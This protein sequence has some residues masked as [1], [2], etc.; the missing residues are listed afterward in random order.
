LEGQRLTDDTSGRRD[1]DN[2][3]LM[4]AYHFPPFRGSSGLQRT[5]SFCRHLPEHGWRPIVLTVHPRAYWAIRSDQLSDIP[6]QIPVVR[7]F[8][9]DSSRHLSVHGVY[10]RLLALPDQWMTWWFG[11][12]PAGLRLIR[13]YRPKLIWSTHPIATAHLIGSSLHR[14][15]GVPWIADFRDPMIEHDQKTG[16]MFPEDALQRRAYL[17]IE[18]QVAKR[19]VRAT[20]C[21]QGALE[22]TRRRHPGLPEG[23]WSVIENG[24]DETPFADAER[25]ATESTHAGGPCVLL[26]SGLLYTSE[27]RNP[28]AFFD[29][30]KQLVS[31]GHISKT[32]LQVV[33]RATGHDEIYGKL[34]AE[35]GLQ[36]IVRLKPPIPYR[37][38]LA[39]MLT[40]DGLLVVQ[41][42]TSNHAIPA[43]LYEYIRARRPILALV[44]AEG[45]TAK[46]LRHLGIETIVPNDDVAQIAAG[47]ADFLARL[48]GNWAKVASPELVRSYSREARAAEL[49][50]LFDSVAGLRRLRADRAP[51]LV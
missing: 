50:A 35:R 30:L 38:A 6:A 41:G 18:R 20:F 47:L 49:A 13:R 19:A 25:H 14:L 46:L 17:A 32:R 27:S 21:T 2:R 36:D 22:L 39:E 34:I 5:L 4:I 43:K 3:V 12:V 9:L 40:A 37:E 51:A 28:S 31:N 29:A 1:G 44:H 24:Y 15:T 48:D 45:E 16:Y 33:L 23:R 11:G 42:F 7:A 8:A 26:H 10:P